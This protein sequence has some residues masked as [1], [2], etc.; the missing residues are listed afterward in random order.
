MGGIF[1]STTISTSDKRINSMRIQQSAY[2]LTQPLVYGKNRVAANMFW[3]GDF[4]AT[5]HTT[6][7][8]SGGKGGKTKT[9]NTTYTYSASLML[10]LCETKIRDIGNIW[11]DKEQIVPKTEGGVQLKPI[12]QLG[13]E[14]F[15]GDQNP[16]WGYLAS[17]H[18]DQAVHYPF[19]GYIACAN[20][21]LGGSASLSNHNFEVISDITFSDT[22]HDANPADVIED[23]ITNP[24]YGAA[25]SLNMAD[26]S[27]FRTYCAAT[28]LL[29]SPA[30]TEQRAA[31]EIINEIVEVVNCAIVPSPDGLKIRSYGDT[32]VSGNGV[33]FTPD[34]TPA[35]HLTDDDFIG[36]DQ[37]VRV[38]RS[39]DTDAFNHCQIEYVNRFNQY[40]TETVEAKDQANIEMFGL[41]TQDPVKYD[42]FC[43]PKIARHAVQL[44]LQRKLYVR[45]EYEFDLGWKYCR[46]E[47]MD[48]V[49][50]TDESL[51][52][53]RFPVRITRIEEDQDGLLTVTAEELALG[54]RSAV[55][56]DLQASNGYQGGNEEP[57]NVNAPV[58]FEPPLEL[59]DGK[60]QIWVAASGGINW[61]GCNVWASIDNT[62]YEMIGTIYGSARYGTLVS[63]IDADDTSMQVQLNTSSQIFGGTLEDAEVDA[64]LCKVGDE[65]INYVD[66]TLDGSGRYTLSGMLRGRF[67]DAS[68]HNA[69]ESFVRIDRAIFEYDFNPNM[70]GKEVY[71]KFTS[72]NGLE[73]KEETLDEVTA[74][75]YTINGGRPAGVKGLSLQSAFEGTSFKVQWQSAAG[76]TGYIVQIWSNG[77]LLRTVDTTNTDYSYSMDEAKIDG[78][79]R[80]YTVRVA[81]KNGSIVSTFAELNISN[82]V[83]PQLLNVYTSATAD[84]ITVTWIPSEVPDLKDYQVWISTNAIFDPD[85]T[86]ARWTGTENACTITGL[87]S[88]TTYYVRVA[89]RDVWKPTSW[90]YSS[91]IT[92]AT[93]DS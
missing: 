64:T 65:Y 38:K 57:G 89:A 25:P 55:E 60:N 42:F 66:A 51:G 39:R 6:T 10:G 84:S 62:T 92:Q 83:P 73:Q 36:D 4:K 8:K 85:T 34:L 14:L 47:P 50:L 81:S 32:A 80:A 68:S 46:L 43:E 31:H 19:L 69:G 70:I 23:F 86:A 88:T 11:R 59:T 5:A 67:D 37:P 78:I 24:R 52:L 74:Y 3:Y 53:D 82:P 91:R 87:Q 1:G 26:L 45:N 29:I 2:G 27:E 49:T 20:Y 41:R 90:N 71:L 22:I 17:M 44:L 72:F 77:V 75:S 56:Y 15:D 63:A 12:D 16:V 58:I 30:L 54:S 13:F 21:D 9:K 61:G 93:T 18:P 35:Y 28:N 79:Q 76:A 33:T 7:T 48:I 40:N